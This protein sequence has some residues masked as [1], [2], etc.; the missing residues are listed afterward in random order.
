M[1]TKYMHLIDGKPAYFDGDQLVYAGHGVRLD[2]LL[3]DSLHE[4]RQQRGASQRFRYKLKDYDDQGY[5][6]LRV[7][8]SK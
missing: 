2:E 4:I 7:R 1:T 6:Y 5:S 3:V 8:V